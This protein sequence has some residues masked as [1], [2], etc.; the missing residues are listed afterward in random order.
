MR[1]VRPSNAG[2]DAARQ[3]RLEIGVEV[4]VREMREIRALGADLLRDLDRLRDAEV[5]R[6]LGAKE[7]VDAPAPSTPRNVRSPRAECSWR[8]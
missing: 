2:R 4:V 6:M 7:R 8:R 3:L 5:R 1:T